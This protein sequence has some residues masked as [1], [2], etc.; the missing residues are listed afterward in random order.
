MSYYVLV[1][2]QQ[3]SPKRAVL[4]CTTFVHFLAKK[5]YQIQVDLPVVIW[6]ALMNFFINE[7]SEK[8]HK[9][10]RA[11]PNHPWGHHKC[12][13]GGPGPHLSGPIFLWC[14]PGRGNP[15]FWPLG[16]GIPQ[17]AKRKLPKKG[18]KP[19]PATGMAW[20]DAQEGV[21]TAGGMR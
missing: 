12:L 17:Q 21:G 3:I 20:G 13:L 10:C 8:Y 4:C 6:V 19:E 5:C 7:P 1:R 14:R 18:A 2:K 16:A 9:R 15:L 11:R